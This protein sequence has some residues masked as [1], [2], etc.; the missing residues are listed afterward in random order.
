MKEGAGL[1]AVEETSEEEATRLYRDVA[2]FLAPRPGGRRR[3]ICV[4]GWQE[5]S[6][7]LECI[8][9]LM[10]DEWGDCTSAVIRALANRVRRHDPP[11]G[12]CPTR[13]L[14]RSER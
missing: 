7:P 1:G 14:D 13:R 11:A 12:C 8:A 5:G 4:S 10:P 6:E 3:E 2:S 9:K